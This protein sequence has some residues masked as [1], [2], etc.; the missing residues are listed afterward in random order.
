MSIQNPFYTANQK[1]LYPHRIVTTSKAV[2]K[3]HLKDLIQK[4]FYTIDKLCNTPIKEIN[5][6]ILLNI[7]SLQICDILK[8]IQIESNTL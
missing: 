1:L 7:C 3:A 6:S 2:A 5:N 4:Q 8:E